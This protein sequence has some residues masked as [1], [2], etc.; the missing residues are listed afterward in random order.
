M[1]ALG[2]HVWL[3]ILA[4]FFTIQEPQELL[5]EAPV[6]FELAGSV[7]DTQGNAIDEASVLLICPLGS[8]FLGSKFGAEPFPVFHATTDEHGSFKI[9]MD[10]TD[11]RLAFVTDVDKLW[12][13][14][15]HPR[16]VT[17]VQPCETDR[18]TVRLPWTV[19]LSDFWLRCISI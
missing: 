12:V 9:S 14:I 10:Y 2:L 3:G 1:H 13:V 7:R 16:Y 19:T 6:T 11:Q 8:N 17:K 18:L 4:C 5:T 15:S